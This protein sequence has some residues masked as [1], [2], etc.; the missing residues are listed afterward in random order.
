MLVEAKQAR[1]VPVV[2]LSRVRL[3]DTE[4][5]RY[6]FGYDVS[7][8]WL[9]RQLAEKEARSENNLVCA[10]WK[11][12]AR[13]LCLIFVCTMSRPEYTAPPEVVRTRVPFPI[14]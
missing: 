10:D 5:S 12:L 14:P 9:M 1:T 7:L 3:L 6:Q 2:P 8:T 11:H 13:V 4:I